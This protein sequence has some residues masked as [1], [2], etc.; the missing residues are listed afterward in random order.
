MR[1][2]N[3][4]DWLSGRDLRKGHTLQGKVLE[5]T[6]EKGDWGGDWLRGWRW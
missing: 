5:T 1:G 3:A 2:A 6:T 4:E